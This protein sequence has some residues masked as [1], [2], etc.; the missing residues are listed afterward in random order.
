MITQPQAIAALRRLLRYRT[1][2]NECDCGDWQYRRR[3]LLQPCKHINLFRD[4]QPQLEAIKIMPIKGLTT[5]RQEMLPRIGKIRL[6]IKKKHS[7]GREYPAA[8]D[9]FV[10][11]PEV[12]AIY[13]AEPKELTIVLPT[14]DPEVVAPTWYKAYQLGRGLA[15]KGD[16]ETA[17]R[18]IADGKASVD[19]AGRPQG[20]L[21]TRDD[22]KVDWHFGLRCPGRQCPDYEKGNCREMMNFQFLMPDVEGYGVWQMDTGSYHGITGIYDSLAYLKLFGDVAGVPLRLT[23]EPKEVSPDGRKK[24]VHVPRL[25]H[26]GKLADMLQAV[27]RPRWALSAAV[28]P[29]PDDSPDDLLHSPDGFAPDGVLPVDDYDDDSNGARMRR[30]AAGAPATIPAADLDTGEI[31]DEPPRQTIGQLIAACETPGQ[32]TALMRRIF[33]GMESGQRRDKMLARISHTAEE[34]GYVVD[35]ATLEVSAVEY[36]EV[37]DAPAL[38]PE[39]VDDQVICVECGE[40][41]SEAQVNEVGVCSVCTMPINEPATAVML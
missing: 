19:E 41:V 15:C 28:M 18:L 17:N 7:N 36:D 8:T 1:T 38:E 22:E 25:T 35:L 13:G 34:T 6:G 14:A 32:Y 12:Q 39:V 11:P 20:P 26:A 21:P 10:C 40:E 4:L 27:E 5:D 31:I 37:D 9:Y 3:Q 16:G 24:T 30:V 33:E 2:A 29:E 23:L